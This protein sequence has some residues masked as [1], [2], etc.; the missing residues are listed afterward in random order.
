MIAVGD[1]ETTDY[2]THLKNLTREYSLESCVE[3]LGFQTDVNRF[4]QQSDLFVLPS[5]FGEGMPMVLLEAMAVGI[6]VIGTDV[7][8]VPEVVRDGINGRIAAAG[9]ATSL[10]TAISSFLSGQLSWSRV[11]ASVIE[12]QR[13]VFSAQSMAQGVA[14][15]YNGLLQ[16]APV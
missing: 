8:G 5:L 9:D 6:P 11:R 12:R 3:W 13:W 16:P 7:E 1:F 2:E 15:I 14:R 4:L 10:S